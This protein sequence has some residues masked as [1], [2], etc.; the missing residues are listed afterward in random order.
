MLIKSSDTNTEIRMDACLGLFSPRMSRS[1]KFYSM[2]CFDLFTNQFLAKYYSN[3]A[4]QDFWPHRN[5]HQW[6][7]TYYLVALVWSEAGRL[8]YTRLSPQVSSIEQVPY[9]MPLSSRPV[10]K[11]VTWLPHWSLHASLCTMCPLC[12]STVVAT[13]PFLAGTTPFISVLSKL[14]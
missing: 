9:G 11:T 14:L 8:Y 7:S 12:S 6:L 1:T 5:P 13:P 3:R 10:Q 4:S 2:Q